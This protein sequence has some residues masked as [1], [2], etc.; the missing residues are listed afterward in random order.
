MKVSILTL[1]FL[2]VLAIALVAPGGA[3]AQAPCQTN[4]DPVDATDPS[5][6][7]S[8]PASGASVASPLHVEGQ[9]RVFE[10]TVSLALY[11]ADG[12]EITSAT[13]NAAEGQ[14]LS[15]FSTGVPF[16]VTSDTPA[17]LWVFEASAQDGSPVNVV[18]VPLTLK[19]TTLP[20]TGTGPA[21]GRETLGWL[22]A[23]LALGGISLLCAGRLATR[24]L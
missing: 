9:A 22:I 24:R 18:Q 23:A 13:T 2:T 1:A 10:A 16:T 17:C 19:A 8:E 4:P 21:D 11:D 14:V 3:N 6:I 7:V 15:A 5:V 12:D 20:P